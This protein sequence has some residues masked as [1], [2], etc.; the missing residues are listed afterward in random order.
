MK[1]QTKFF[2]QIESDESQVISFP[3]G[4]PGFP[5]E[6]KFLLLPF[7]GSES[8]MLCLQS[9]TTPELAFV[10]LDPFRFNSS[11][12]PVLQ[13][14]ELEQLGVETSEELYYYVLCAVHNPVSESTVNLRCPV[15]INP[16]TLEGRQIIMDTDEYDMRY[17]LPEF[18][19]GA[20]C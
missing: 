1:L 20:T 17:P 12:A 14:A 9:A 3:V 18:S 4:I 11:Y 5:N 7:A 19:G 8:V 13:P 6:K 10:V 15:A 16:N 2:G